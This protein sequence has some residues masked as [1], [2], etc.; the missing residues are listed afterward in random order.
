MVCFVLG[1]SWCLEALRI[2]SVPR[3]RRI[4]TMSIDTFEAV[5]KLDCLA[6]RIASISL[7]WRCLFN[8][9]STQG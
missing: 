8:T 1:S 9:V 6:R 7:L 4:C 5:Y 2:V 3:R